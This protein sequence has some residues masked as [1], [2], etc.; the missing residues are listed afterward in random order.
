MLHY[1]YPLIYR[2]PM[3]LLPG[4]L[5]LVAEC[6]VYLFSTTRQLMFRCIS[7]PRFW[8]LFHRLKSSVTMLPL[9]SLVSPFT[10]LRLTALSSVFIAPPLMLIFLVVLPCIRMPRFFRPKIVLLCPV[11]SALCSH[12]CLC[13]LSQ[14]LTTELWHQRLGHSDMHQLQ[15]LQQFSTGLPSASEGGNSN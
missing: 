7:V 6:S 12:Y 11:A 15:H 9:C 3:P 13:H 5:V 8:S 14:V 4:C 1:L 2:V 10:A